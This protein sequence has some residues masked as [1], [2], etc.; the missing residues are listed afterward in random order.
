MLE[1]EVGMIVIL[2]LQLRK[3]RVREVEEIA[4]DHSIDSSFHPSNPVSLDS[5]TH[6]LKH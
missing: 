4:H 3:L 6:I 1:Y 5:K 2:I